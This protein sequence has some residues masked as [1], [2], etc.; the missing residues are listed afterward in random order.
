MIAPARRPSTE[1]PSLFVIWFRVGKG[2]RWTKVGRAGTHAEAVTMC[3]SEGDWHV[4][5]LKNP[6]LAGE[7]CP[8]ADR[9]FCEAPGPSD[10]VESK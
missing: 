10:G 3:G 5:E 8:T 7:A 1:A 9:P 4:A 2:H 6:E